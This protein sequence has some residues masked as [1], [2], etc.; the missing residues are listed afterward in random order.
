MTEMGASD[1]CPHIHVCMRDGVLRLLQSRGRAGKDSKGCNPRVT[2]RIRMFESIRRCWH[3][4]T[5][6]AASAAAELTDTG[7]ATM[8]MCVCVFRK[9]HELSNMSTGSI[10]ILTEAS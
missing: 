1:A 7:Q 6:A 2:G 5:S 4:T 3:S 9:Q 10:S 8:P